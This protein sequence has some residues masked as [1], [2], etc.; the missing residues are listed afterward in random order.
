MQRITTIP[1]LRFIATWLHDDTNFLCLLV[2]YWTPYFTLAYKYILE[3]SG[4]N[5]K[6]DG[7]LFLLEHR[8]LH[9]DGGRGRPCMVFWRMEIWITTFSSRPIYMATITLEQFTQRTT[10][11]RWEWANLEQDQVHTITK[12]RLVNTKNGESCIITLRDRRS[13]WACSG[14]Q[15][16]LTNNDKLPKYI[17]SCGK[18]AA[19]PQISTGY[20]K[21]LMLNNSYSVYFKKKIGQRG[22][23]TS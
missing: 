2:D 22:F 13:F 4:R 19:N 20:F 8:L 3:I 6:W 5:Q 17:V 14:L 7:F 10:S 23:L 1:Q 16:A 11:W 21:W 12:V 18:K 15:K 9:N